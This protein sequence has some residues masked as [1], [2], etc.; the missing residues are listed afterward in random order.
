MSDA[1]TARVNLE[2]MLESG[3][4]TALLRFALGNE[5]LK[6][7]DASAAALHLARA[8]ELDPQYTAAWKTY[9]RALAQCDQRAS[10][11][12]AYERGIAVAQAKGDK[13][14]EKEMRVFLRRLA[15]ELEGDASGGG[16]RG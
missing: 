16:E 1:S 7:N 5:C 14:A 11:L 13:Q 2:R 8:V 10:A 15:R 4:D 6:S 3:K 12:Q 9:A